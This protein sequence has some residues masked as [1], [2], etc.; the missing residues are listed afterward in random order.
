MSMESAEKI[1]KRA[2]DWLARRDAGDWSAQEQS[3]FDAWMQESVAHRIA[4]WRLETVWDETARLRALG[5]GVQSEKPPPP[6]AWN[7]SP[8]FTQHPSD[9]RDGLTELLGK[10]K[11]REQSE[12]R[13]KV[14]RALAAG[15][16]LVLATASVW[17][18]WPEGRS[19]STP[20]G[21]IASLPMS[22]GSKVLLNTDSKIKVAINE[23]ERRVVL[24]RGEAFFDVAKDPVRPFI[25]TVDDKRIVAIGTRFSVR[26]DPVLQ[27]VV[28]QGAVRVESAGN[29]APS[30]GAGNSGSERSKTAVLT[31]GSIARSARD[32]LQV[33]HADVP[34]AEEQ[35][36]WR[37]G[38]L[39]FRDIALADAVAE[40]NRYN[41]R[42]IVIEDS[43]AAAL[44]I[45][46]VV[47]TTNVDAFV[48]LLE[49]GYP[50]H[51]DVHPDKIILTTR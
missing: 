20:V 44:T 39:V 33:R 26:R 23:K 17:Y 19:Y 31:A 42:K 40:F 30:A 47:R 15:V 25:V 7:L 21:A 43:A 14:F 32:G 18:V 5:A 28:T 46:G 45:G 6:G 51:A 10:V 35:L 2:G 48:Q 3:A 41:E 36:T 38:S 8:F 27:V 1:E 49:E 12:R 22:D 4:L 9:S 29:S 16:L 13:V 11:H 24:S 34:Q 50:L 37:A